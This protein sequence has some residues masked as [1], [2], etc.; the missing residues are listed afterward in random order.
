MLALISLKLEGATLLVWLMQAITLF[1]YLAFAIG[2][3][4]VLLM[5]GDAFN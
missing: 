5:Q 2:S 1:A 3:F 4:V